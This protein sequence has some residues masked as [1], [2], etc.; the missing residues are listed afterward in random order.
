MHDTT[1]YYRGWF[2]FVNLTLYSR[3]SSSNKSYLF[4][5]SKCPWKVMVFLLE[6]TFMGF[7]FPLHSSN[8]H[9]VSSPWTSAIQPPRIFI[10]RFCL[11]FCRS[12]SLF[13][14]ILR[15]LNGVLNSKQKTCSFFKLVMNMQVLGGC[16]VLMKQ[17]ASFVSAS[18]NESRCEIQG[19]LHTLFLENEAQT[20]EKKTK[21]VYI[22]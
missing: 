6:D 2:L 18:F 8:S 11:Q 15:L 17:K 21:T 9:F 16:I 19:F 3:F 5:T 22:E 12:A 7:Y 13:K 1:F 10:T 4:S 14:D 20:S